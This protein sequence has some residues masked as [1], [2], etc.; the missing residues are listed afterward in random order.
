VHFIQYIK[1]LTTSALGSS[2]GCPR[3]LV[4]LSIGTPTLSH[5]TYQTWQ[6]YL[7]SALMQTQLPPTIWTGTIDM[8]RKLPDSPMSRA[9]NLWSIVTLTCSTAAWDSL[10]SA[11]AGLVDPRTRTR[12][13]AKGY[14]IPQLFMHRQA[15]HLKTPFLN[16]C[17]FPMRVEL[18]DMFTRRKLD[19]LGAVARERTHNLCKKCKGAGRANI[20]NMISVDHAGERIKYMATRAV[21]QKLETGA[22]CANEFSTTRDLVFEPRT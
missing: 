3:N 20:R 4:F 17:I 10:I 22:A 11:T 19:P 12:L 9:S 6:R 7:I 5:Q 18:V 14:T 13:V 21:N 2:A 1:L 15:P 8:P 16:L